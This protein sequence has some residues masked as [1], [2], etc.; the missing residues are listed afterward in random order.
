[1]GFKELLNSAY[2]QLENELADS[3]NIRMAQDESLIIFDAFRRVCETHD[4]VF[5]MGGG[6][7]LGA[8][9]HQGFIPWDDDIDINMPREDFERFKDVSYELG[10]SFV[11][12]APNYNDSAVERFG[13]IFILK[14]KNDGNWLHNTS[15]DIFVIE[16]IPKNCIYRKIKG[17]ISTFGMGLAAASLF[18][19]NRTKKLKKTLCVSIK[20][21]FSYYIR[22]CI[23]FLISFIPAVKLYNL[24][25]RL[26]QYNKVTGI[27][28]VPS[29]RKHYFGEQFP[30]HVYLPTR[31]GNFEGRRVPLENN[32]DLYLTNLYGKDYM[33]LPP[34]KQRERHLR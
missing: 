22:V 24:A 16:N 9:R 31:D 2:N 7:T 11:F 12:C 1:M 33:E 25:D 34:E 28:G 19:N 6:S 15:I 5:M 30:T 29:G 13:K 3:F 18:Y 17:I 21:C 14:D 32:I 4:I 20:G 8:V 27:L 23:G 10:D 26:N